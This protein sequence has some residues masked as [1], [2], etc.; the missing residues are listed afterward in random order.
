M[1]VL[2]FGGTSVGTPESL[3][4]VRAIVESLTEP[5][6]VTVSALG[7]I[8]DRL[9][10]AADAAA[11][12]DMSY[13]GIYEEICTRHRRVCEAVVSSAR[14][15]GVW[16]EVETL[17]NELGTILKA[18]NLL[19]EITE[20]TRDL[21]VSY[22]ERMSCIIVTSMIP[23]AV[24]AQSLDFIRT[25]RSFGKSVLDQE[26][27]S[28]LVAEKFAEAGDA[29]VV[30]VPG[31]IARDVDGRISN[32]GRGGSD[33]TAAI[34]ASELNASVLEIWTDVDGFMTADPRIVKSA[35]VIDRLS[36]V[37][38]MELCNF[39]AKVVY[40]PTIYP[41]FHKN[42]PIVIKNTF[43]PTVPGTLIGDCNVKTSES[44]AL[45]VSS[46]AD[47][48]LVSVPDAALYSRMIN[49]LTGS[50]IET[51]LADGCRSCG[52]KGSDSERASTLLREALA[53]ELMA[54]GG[55]VKVSGRL[56]TVAL[57]GRGMGD[58]RLPGKLSNTLNV[59]GIPIYQAPQQVSDGSVACMVAA[60]DLSDALKTI[61]DNL[62]EQS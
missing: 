42:I 37:E 15:D 51:M 27:T 20:R 57:I 33:Y 36:F 53:S 35:R 12:G 43:N 24:S 52:I 60:E 59:A 18:V 54:A 21:V 58:E 11:A 28:A 10:A 55:D 14:I 17:L 6:V 4:N 31:F 22:G 5:S 13:T 40:P 47:T 23:G 1:K 32:L 44:K 16:S 50:G 45:G 19:G 61:H 46:L 29:K 3:A 62:I 7:G 41:V 38:A 49:L 26:S 48:R 30:V 9:I 39:G 56:C 2:K 34:L 8:T 25:R